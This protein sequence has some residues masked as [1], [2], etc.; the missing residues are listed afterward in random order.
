[1]YSPPSSSLRAERVPKLPVAE[2]VSYRG[3]ATRGIPAKEFINVPS[4]MREPIGT[5][6]LSWS[7]SA[8]VLPGVPDL[9]PPSDG[10]FI[11]LC[12][13]NTYLSVPR[14]SHGPFSAAKRK[15]HGSLS[16]GDL[17]RNFSTGNGYALWHC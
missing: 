14:R 1:M 6:L 7:D 9:N 3:G 16:F 5:T 8:T 15:K 2:R 17:R 4:S 13:C 11:V 10:R 12:V